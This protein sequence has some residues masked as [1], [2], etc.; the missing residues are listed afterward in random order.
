MEDVQS[1]ARA[2][3]H[4][5]ATVSTRLHQPVSNLLMSDTFALG[6]VFGVA[7]QASRHS[8]GSSQDEVS[9][10]YIENVFANLVEDTKTAHS[11]ILFVNH[12]RYEPAFEAGYLRGLTDL[13]HWVLPL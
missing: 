12:Q 5:L 13:N 3:N 1:V 6:Y 9:K 11:L 4:Q 8:N 2:A 10:K 7:E